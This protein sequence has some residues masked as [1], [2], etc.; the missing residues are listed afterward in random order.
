MLHHKRKAVI[1]F[2]P[3]NGEWYDYLAYDATSG[4][5]IATGSE[6]DQVQRECVMSG[7]RIISRL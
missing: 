7:Y 1:V 4:R 2:C 5:V 3:T 6:L